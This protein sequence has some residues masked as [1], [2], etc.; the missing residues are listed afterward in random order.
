MSI[1]ELPW[2]CYGC[3]KWVTK[4]K[5][6]WNCDNSG[7]EAYCPHCIAA[8]EDSYRLREYQGHA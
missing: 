2:L 8:I 5:E 3:G 7:N 6:W 1:K 4:R